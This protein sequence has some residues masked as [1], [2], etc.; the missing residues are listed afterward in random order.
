M[1]GL[2]VLRARP[3]TQR[4]PVVLL[5]ADATATSRRRGEALGADTYLSKPLDIDHLLA[6]IDE[7]IVRV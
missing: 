7:L 3:E 6:M 4:I 2:D 1:P 5:T